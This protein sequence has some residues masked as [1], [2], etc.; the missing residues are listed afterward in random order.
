QWS[1]N[2]PEFCYLPRKFKI[3]VTGAAA[4]RA[5]IGVHD[6]GLRILRHPETGHL[7]YEVRIGGGLGRTPLIGKLVRAFLPRQDLLAYLEAA[8]RVYNA[9]GRRVNKFKARVKILVH[10][11]GVEE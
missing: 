7:G 8:M 6:I 9:E 3:A 10:E 2:H 11:L 1:S 4:D 5:A